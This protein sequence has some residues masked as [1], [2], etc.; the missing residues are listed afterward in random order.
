MILQAESHHVRLEMASAGIVYR[1]VVNDIV[2][3]YA[4]VIVVLTLDRV[5]C[6]SN[7]VFVS[8]IHNPGSDEVRLRE[9]DVYR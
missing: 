2:S 6:F 3:L 5:E 7:G 1:P 4:R 9:V 8:S